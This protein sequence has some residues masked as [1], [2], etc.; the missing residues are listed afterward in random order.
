MLWFGAVEV[1]GWVDS[2]R[3]RERPRETETK[4]EVGGLE[5]MLSK[6]QNQEKGSHC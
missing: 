3:E 6:I 4:T 5:E 2:D 1:R